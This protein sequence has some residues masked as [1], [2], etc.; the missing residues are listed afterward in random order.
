MYLY[1]HHILVSIHI[2]YQYIIHI[3]YINIPLSY[4]ILYRIIHLLLDHTDT[5]LSLRSGEP[6]L[7]PLDPMAGQG[8]SACERRLQCIDE[9]SNAFSNTWPG[10]MQMVFQ[11]IR[12]LKQLV[13]HEGFL[14]II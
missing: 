3:P 2:L 8:T 12:L 9:Q 1:I 11:D 13:K 14:Y 10:E 4:H 5:L 7:P 6:S